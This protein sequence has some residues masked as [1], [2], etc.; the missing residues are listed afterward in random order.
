M[1]GGEDMYKPMCRECYH[2]VAND[3][4]RKEAEHEMNGDEAGKANSE[5]KVTLRNS[6]VDSCTASSEES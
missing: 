3:I 5:E 1:I 4:A 6:Q 2:A